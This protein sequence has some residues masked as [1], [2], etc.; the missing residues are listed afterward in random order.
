MYSSQAL[1]ETMAGNAYFFHLVR[2]W[3]GCPIHFP[4]RVMVPSGEGPLSRPI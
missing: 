2:Q 1:Q 3:Q 4:Q